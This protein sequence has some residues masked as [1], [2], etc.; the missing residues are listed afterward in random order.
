MLQCNL[1]LRVPVPRVPTNLLVWPSSTLWACRSGSAPFWKNTFKFSLLSQNV[2]CDC[3][4]FFETGPPSTRVTDM[5][6]H[7]SGHA[8]MPTAYQ[9]RAF[10]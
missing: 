5:Q 2:A 9:A 10:F 3:K 8:C 1:P 4:A 7:T 6:A